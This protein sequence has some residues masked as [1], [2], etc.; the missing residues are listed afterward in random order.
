MPV[1]VQGEVPNG[2]TALDCGDS[3]EPFF[4]ML[5]FLLFLLFL[6]YFFG[7]AFYFR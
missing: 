5:G 6:K 3:G 4:K 7:Q 2:A 1:S